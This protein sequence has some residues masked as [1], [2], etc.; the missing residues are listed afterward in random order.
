MHAELLCEG[1]REI[2]AAKLSAAAR[3]MVT[4]LLEC[5]GAPSYEAQYTVFGKKLVTEL[6]SCFKTQRIGKLEREVAWGAFH[7]LRTSVNFKELWV[8]FIHQVTGKTPVSSILSASHT[9]CVQCDC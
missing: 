3:E 5:S 9:L 7:Q 1:L 8:A 4:S 6:E 2:Q